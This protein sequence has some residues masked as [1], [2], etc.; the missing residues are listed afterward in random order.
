MSIKRKKT[1]TNFPFSLTSHAGKSP[2]SASLPV[3]HP[4]ILKE[5]NCSRTSPVAMTTRECDNSDSSW[6]PWCGFLFHDKTLGV[7]F[8]LSRYKAPFGSKE[9]KKSVSLTFDQRTKWTLKDIKVCKT[10]R[11]TL[12]K[13]HFVK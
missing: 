4:P 3:S 10:Q 6:F 7:R 1:L 2:A 11:F 12:L 13:S 9:M 5:D 8:D